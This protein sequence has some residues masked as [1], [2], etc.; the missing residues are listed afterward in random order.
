MEHG[1][2]VLAWQQTEDGGSGKNWPQPIG[3]RGDVKS[4]GVRR[5]SLQVDAL[6]AERKAR[7]Q[8]ELQAIKEGT[9]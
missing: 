2:R 1:I 5:D 7:R 8:A 9:A 6:L 4:N 3:L